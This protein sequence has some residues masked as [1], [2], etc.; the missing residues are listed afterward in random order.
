MEVDS[1][2]ESSRAERTP[3]FAKRITQVATLQHKKPVSSVDAEIIGGST[4]SSLGIL[5]QETS[6]GSSKGT[7]LK[8]GMLFFPQ[9]CVL[10]AE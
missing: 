5:K 2:K 1:A 6:I 10:S 3:A 4:F 7:I 8:K 9:E